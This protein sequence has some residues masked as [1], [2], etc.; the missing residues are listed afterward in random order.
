M[1][2]TDDICFYAVKQDGRVLKHVINKTEII[3]LAAVKQTEWALE[4]VNDNHFD[5][6]FGLL[7]NVCKILLEEYDKEN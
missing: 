4:Y 5:I 3:C 2:Q 7:E 6:C 1:K